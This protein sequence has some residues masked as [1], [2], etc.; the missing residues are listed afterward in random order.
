MVE[1]LDEHL[2]TCPGI[3]YPLGT[4]SIARRRLSSLRSLFQGECLAQ[5]HSTIPTEFE[6]LSGR[7]AELKQL[8]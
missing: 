8:R 7:I 1:R 4:S 5:L 3:V 6:K 2:T